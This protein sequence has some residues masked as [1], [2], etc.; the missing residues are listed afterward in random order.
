MD[1]MELNAEVLEKMFNEEE[2]PVI[3]LK[4]FE[5]DT[6]VKGHHF[7]KDI[8]TPKIGENLDAQI[9][10]NNPVNLENLWDI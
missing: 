1:N 3:A 7:Y 2:V 6:Y 4:E 10:P 8:W 9:K 5:T